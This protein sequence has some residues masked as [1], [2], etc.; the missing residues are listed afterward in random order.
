MKNEKNYM[1]LYPK[2][3]A[4]FETF[5]WSISSSINL[6][7]LKSG[8]SISTMVLG[9]SF[10]CRICFDFIDGAVPASSLRMS[11]RSID[12]TQAATETAPSMKSKKFGIKKMNLIP[13]C[14]FQYWKFP[15]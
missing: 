13:I 2:S 4:N 11:M 1:F 8:T 9:L 5:H 12:L 14:S 10:L 3:M 15:K 7:F 6:L